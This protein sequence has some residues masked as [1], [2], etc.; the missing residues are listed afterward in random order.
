MADHP[1]LFDIATAGPELESVYEFRYR[2]YVEEMQRTQHYADHARRRIVD[3]LD[4]NGHQIV[5]RQRDA[6]VGVVRINLC[7]ERDVGYYRD[8]CAMEVAGSDHPTATSLCTRLMVAPE[9]RRSTLAVRLCEFVYAFAMRQGIR[10]NFIDCNDHLV[11]FFAGLGYVAHVARTMHPEYGMVNPMHLRL[12][13]RAHL[14]RVRSPFLR[15]LLRWE[16][17]SLV[18]SL[19]EA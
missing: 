19:A 15:T 5:A 13:D 8:L 3:P 16:R 10:H 2:I 17:D 11:P 12:R 9:F 1:V 6:L 7:G 18:G 4:A 14:T